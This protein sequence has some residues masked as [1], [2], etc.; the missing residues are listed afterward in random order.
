MEYKILKITDELYPKKLKDIKNPP[1]KLFYIGDIELL[2]EPIFAVIGTR[3]ITNYGRE[4]TKIFTNNLAE[5]F[6]IISGMAVGTDTVA[7]KSTLDVGGKTIAVLG[8]GFNNIFPKENIG[9]FNEIIKTGGLILTEYSPSVKP[10]S[11]NFPARNRIVSGL[12]DG[13]LVIEAAYRSGT[14]ITVDF[15]KQQ[16]K[17]VFAIPGRLDSKYGVGVNKLIQDGAILVTEIGDII[18]HYPQIMRKMWKNTY[19]EREIKE[20]YKEIFNL[21]EES[22]KG[23]EELVIKIENRTIREIMNLLSLMELDGIIKQEIGVGY[24]IV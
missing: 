19:Q 16:G 21:L 23:L 6:V 24:K 20:E 22:P 10:K 7:H 12:S 11:Q 1:K 18:K 17:K 9:L 15:A 3:H 8:N 4:I 14:S 2:K 5:E 13:V